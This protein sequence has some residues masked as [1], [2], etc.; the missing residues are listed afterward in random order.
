MADQ[1]QK[2]HLVDSGNQNNFGLW[3]ILIFPS[4]VGLWTSGFSFSYA[5]HRGNDKPYQKCKLS[6]SATKEI[7]YLL[8]QF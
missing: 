8:M 1:N 4:A 3:L 7:F 6:G 2:G 5:Q